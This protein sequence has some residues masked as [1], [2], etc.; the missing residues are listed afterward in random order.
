MTWK[1]T[2]KYQSLYPSAKHWGLLFYWQSQFHN[3][4]VLLPQ[5]SFFQTFNCFNYAN[6]LKICSHTLDFML[7]RD[8]ARAWRKSTHP[9]RHRAHIILVNGPVNKEDLQKIL[10]IAWPLQN[11]LFRLIVLLPISQPRCSY[12]GFCCQCP[13]AH[14]VL[15]NP[16]R[17]PPSFD[18]S[19]SSQKS[20]QPC[21][22]DTPAVQPQGTCRGQETEARGEIIYLQHLRHAS[23]RG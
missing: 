18:Y 1:F 8:V 20:Q 3:A 6:R 13:H 4:Y 19:P 14:S 17:F 12:F 7:P 9:S 15:P 21:Q 22:T 5:I 10:F 11:G 23:R 2:W 16:W